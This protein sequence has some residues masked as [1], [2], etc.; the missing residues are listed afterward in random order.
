MHSLFPKRKESEG[1]WTKWSDWSTCT[2]VCGRGNQTRERSCNDRVSVR[3]HPLHQS[4]CNDSIHYRLFLCPP[5]RVSSC[6]S[7]TSVVLNSGLQ[8]YQ[9]TLFQ[10]SD[11]KE[12]LCG[13]NLCEKH[14]FIVKC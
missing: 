6:Q 14:Q 1:R 5:I 3:L 12:I 8:T 2:R 4:E 9:P 11:N 7:R 10:C 13:L